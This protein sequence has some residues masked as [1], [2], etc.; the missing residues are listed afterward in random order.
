MAS[1][2]EDRAM[3]GRC[4]Q[5]ARLEADAGAEFGPRPMGQPREAR[6]VVIDLDAVSAFTRKA[7]GCSTRSSATAR[8]VGIEGDKLD[9]AVRQGGREE[10]RGA[11]R[12]GR[13]KGSL[14]LVPPVR[15]NHRPTPRR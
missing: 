5:L 10:G 6:H 9:I 15:M 1:T 14:N 2:I 3:Q 4:L 7:T 11:V 8:I 12:A 13:R